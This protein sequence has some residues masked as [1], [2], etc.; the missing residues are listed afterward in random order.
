MAS[1]SEKFQSNVYSNQMSLLLRQLSYEFLQSEALLNSMLLG[2]GHLDKFD[3]HI[4]KGGRTTVYST[5]VLV[6]LF[7]IAIILAFTK[8]S[9]KAG[10]CV[11][12][13]AC[14]VLITIVLGYMFWIFGVAEVSGVCGIIR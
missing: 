1:I 11:L 13:V 3:G 12:A 9:R 6:I 14:L 5:L 4:K 2:D 8:K 10:Y 7:L